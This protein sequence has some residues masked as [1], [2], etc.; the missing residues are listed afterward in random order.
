[1]NL[2]N[3][4]EYARHLHLRD[5]EVVEIEEDGQHLRI[6][7]APSQSAAPQLAGAQPKPEE[8]K[9]SLPGVVR[10]ES[11]GWMRTSDPQQLPKAIAAGDVVSKGQLLALLEMDGALTT[12]LAPSDGVVEAVLATD[13]DRIDYGKPLFQL[14]PAQR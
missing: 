6:R 4:R 8:R 12:V 13:G 10:S 2:D 14:K 11:L 1:M 5:V 7:I 3:I 9:A